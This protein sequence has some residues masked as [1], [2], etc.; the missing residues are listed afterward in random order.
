MAVLVFACF[1]GC[2]ANNDS[3]TETVKVINASIG[4]IRSKVTST[5]TVQPKN[6]VEI[7]PST[8]GRVEDILVNEG[9]SVKKGQ[10]L[11]WM[12]SEERASLLDAA[13]SKG[14]EE[15]KYWQDVYKPTPLIAPIDG[16]VIVRGIEPGQSVTTATAVLVLSDRLIVGATVDETDIGKIQV[17]QEA[18]IGLD[19]YPDVSARGKVDHISYESKTVNNVTTY[20][21][22]IMPNKVPP[23]F[24]SGMTA[25]VSIY[26]KQKSNILVLPLE[27]VSTDNSGNYVSI[28]T[29]IPG[30]TERR[31]IETGISDLSNVEIKSGITENDKIV[32]SSKKFALGSQSTGTNPFFNPPKARTQ[33]STSTAKGAA[34]SGTGESKTNTAGSGQG[35]AK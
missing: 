21:V 32:I 27:A 10:V 6:R 14:A 24:R 11:V 33:T 15:L 3:K 7:K 20:E 13:R 31:K 8:N 26:D 12:S 30:K 18:L 17:G 34:A 25:N 29:G 16:E 4:S 23:V 1:S 9:D 22:D 2:S 28:D 35:S 19:A 5:G